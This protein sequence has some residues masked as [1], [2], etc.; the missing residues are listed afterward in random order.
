M[1]DFTNPRT[2]DDEALDLLY[3]SLGRVHPLV[4]VPDGLPEATRAEVAR[5][6]EIRIERGEYGDQHD[7]AWYEPRPL[8]ESGWTG[9]RC[10][11]VLFHEGPHSNE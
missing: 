4:V 9:D 3:K 11:F 6:A 1:T 2:L 7:A 8:C 5:R 10:Q